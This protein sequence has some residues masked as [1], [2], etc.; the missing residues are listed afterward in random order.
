M[1]VHYNF[2]KNHKLIEDKINKGIDHKVVSS[3][4]WYNKIT[5]G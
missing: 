3:D 5:Y 2:G 1:K 4:F